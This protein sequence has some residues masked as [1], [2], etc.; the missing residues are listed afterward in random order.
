MGYSDPNSTHRNPT[1]TFK[2]YFV[3][4]Y[5]REIFFLGVSMHTPIQKLWLDLRAH[6]LS[7]A[8][9]V[10]AL[11]PKW[12]AVCSLQIS[13]TLI[14]TRSLIGHMHCI[15]RCTTVI[16]ITHALTGY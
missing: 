14:N 7:L 5:T 16:R 2:L 4:L 12:L 10:G 1:R 8:P 3:A 9:F 13:Q 6:T 11:W 15:V